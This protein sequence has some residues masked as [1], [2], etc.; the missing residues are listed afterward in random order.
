ML[1]EAIICAILAALIGFG[2][3][4]FPQPR[5]ISCRVIALDGSSESQYGAP[6]LFAILEGRSALQHSLGHVECP[7]CEA[8]RAAIMRESEWKNLSF[9]LAAYFWLESRERYI[10]PRTR[11]DYEN[12]IKVLASQIGTLK[13]GE[14]HIGHIRAFQDWRSKTAGNTRINQEL[15]AL[16]QILKRA[17]LWEGISPYYERLPESRPKRGRAITAEDEERLFSVASRNPRWLVAYC[18]SSLTANTTAGPGEIKHLRIGDVDLDKRQ[19]HVRE[20]TK[21]KFRVR[22]IPL[23]STALRQAA[24]LVTRH[25]ELCQRHH[26]ES[27]SEQLLLPHRADHRGGCPDFYRPMYSWYTAW[28]ALCKKAGLVG[29]RPYDLRHLALTKLLEDADVSEETVIALAG[30]VGRAMLKTYSHVRL[31]AR[32]DAVKALEP[33]SVQKADLRIVENQDGTAGK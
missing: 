12:Y 31:K 15:S 29:L 2:A 5:N 19:I 30:H 9:Q 20:G 7:A 18:A 8:S 26:I 28:R 32:E 6:V 21:N 3:G 10:S 25:D 16:V 14:L 27:D 23:N 4:A 24:R 33:K 11:A 13:L 17:D 1:P 22:T